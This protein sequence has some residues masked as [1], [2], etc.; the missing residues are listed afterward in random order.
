VINPLLD[1]LLDAAANC[2]R[3]RQAIAAVPTALGVNS[4]AV[5]PVAKGRWQGFSR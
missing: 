4:C 2:V 3:A 1:P 5:P